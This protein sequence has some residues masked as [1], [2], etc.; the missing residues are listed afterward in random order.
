MTWG[1]IE[2]LFTL[3]GD[4]PRVV[5]FLDALL[6]RL[7]EKLPNRERPCGPTDTGAG[8]ALFELELLLTTYYLLLTTYPF[9]LTTYYL[10][11]ATY[12]LLLTT[13]YLLLT[14][15]YLLLTTY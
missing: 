4:A 11:L 9:L 15:H 14:S 2:A 13:Y 10:L 5:C 3:L 1:D 12:Y 8:R 7:L 6:E